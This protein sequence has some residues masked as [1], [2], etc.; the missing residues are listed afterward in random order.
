MKY[1]LPSRI[2]FLS[3]LSIILFSVPVLA[4]D[5]FGRVKP[6]FPNLKAVQFQ[7]ITF[8]FQTGTDRKTDWGKILVFPKQL[9]KVSK[10]CTGYINVFL[11]AGGSSGHHWVVENLLITKPDDNRCTFENTN[12]FQDRGPSTQSG[13]G[14]Q[15]STA[16][17]QPENMPT[18]TYFSL[19]PE[20]VAVFTASVGKENPRVDKLQAVVLFSSNPFPVVAEVWSMVAESFRAFSFPVVQAVVNAEGDISEI[21]DDGGSTIPPPIVTGNLQMG[22][23]PPPTPIPPDPTVPDLSFPFIVEQNSNPN[24][25]SAV[26]Q[27][28]PMAYANVLAFLQNRYNQRPLLWDLPHAGILGLGQ[29]RS[30]P[31]VPIWE[32]MPT[33]SI[34]AQ[35]DTFTRRVGTF[36]RRVGEGSNRCRNIR[37]L[38]GYLA[39]FGAQAQVVLRHQG[40]REVYGDGASCDS[41]LIDLGGLTSTREGEEVTWEWLRDQIVAGRGVAVSFSR[42]DLAGA[43]SSGH[44]VRVRGVSQYNNKEY[45]MI[46]DDPNQFNDFNTV[47]IFTYELRDKGQPTNANMPN[48]LL[49]IVGTNWELKFAMSVEAKPTLQIP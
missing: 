25:Q 34:V 5:D 14:A 17:K 3:F 22:P 6:V 2:S 29:R 12:V 37:G 11:E 41:T 35:V 16:A 42:Y 45:I 4:V 36:N 10:K 23:A 27:C 32:P 19:K 20:N 31:D 44:M 13:R 30:S 40:G 1:Q 24:T 9:R 48:G 38:L 18:G 28:V 47:Q 7:Q 39:M 21:T 43:W 46:L 8:K 15:L 26:N 49:E 33:T